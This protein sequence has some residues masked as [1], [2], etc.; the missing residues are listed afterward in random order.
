MLHDTG[1]AAPIKV[2]AAARKLCDITFLADR[3]TRQVAEDY[4]AMTDIADVMDIT[5]LSTTEVAQR[6][7]MLPTD[8]ITTFSEFQQRRVA[9]LAAECGFIGHSVET[10]QLLT[11][12]FR[13]RQALATAGTQVT[14]VALVASVDDVEQAAEIVGFPAVLK[15]RRGAAAARTC[16]VDSLEQCLAA[17]ADF[18]DHPDSV[19]V[20]EQLLVGDPLAAGPEW[21]DFVSVES[22]VHDGD[23][24][25]VC[26]TGKQPLAPPF[27]ETGDL[28][29][30]TVPTALEDRIVRLTGDALRAL[31]VRHGVCHTE[32]KLTA[33]G[34]RIIEVNGR[35]AGY[36]S[37]LLHR[38]TGF[39]LTEAVLELALG[40]R[41]DIPVLHWNQLYWSRFVLPPMEASRVISVAPL[42]KLA[43]LPG[44]QS[45]DILAT[46]GQSVDW[47]HG[48]HDMLAILHATASTHDEVLSLISQTEQ[49]AR[50]SCV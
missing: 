19:F 27:R 48:T 46:P 1:S 37:H 3:S 24:Q 41:V 43:A 8:G 11:D 15:P 47:R 40:R 44:V 33:D 10:A 9:E 30:S 34:P 49:A 26:V 45:L 35:M 25:H 7:R 13:Q 42:E 38:A 17:V 4:R 18:A 39:N 32:I 6:I 23:V 5:G 21:G 36:A 22:L 28:M 20:L 31:G 16:R 29:P 50:E 2:A 12:K 14:R